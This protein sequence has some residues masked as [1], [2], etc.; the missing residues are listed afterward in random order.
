[1]L[2]TIILILNKS[3]DNSFSTKKLTRITLVLT[4]KNVKSEK[5]Q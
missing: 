1:M 4:L 5:K 2:K 3:N